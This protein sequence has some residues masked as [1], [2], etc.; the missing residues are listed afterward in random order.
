M[1]AGQ[2]GQ[3]IRIH[4][5]QPGLP[6]GAHDVLRRAQIHRHLA[7]DGGID[8]GK[9]GGGAVDKVHAA[10]VGGGHKAGQIAHNAAAHGHHQIAPVKAQL[11]HPA[12]QA[13]IH[14]QAFAALALGHGFN[15][16]LP[17]LG[18]HDLGVF[19]G[20]AAVGHDEHPP[21]QIGQKAQ[22][23]QRAAL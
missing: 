2:G 8:L 23:V 21:V 4:H 7:A 17:A 1:A 12:Q 18:A 3:G 19:G 13:L 11:Q 9:G 14:L 6:E 5:H 22:I 15:V 16:A 10:H 20:H